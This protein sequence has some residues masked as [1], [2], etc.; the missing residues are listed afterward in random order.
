MAIVMLRI[1]QAEEPGPERI[2][3]LWCAAG[4]IENARR[5]AKMLGLNLQKRIAILSAVMGKLE[6]GTG[7]SLGPP[8]EGRAHL[9]TVDANGK[10][11]HREVSV[12]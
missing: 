4:R 1:A 10:W 12:H 8:F 2:G 3:T 9:V 5:F 11:S 7:E 6:P